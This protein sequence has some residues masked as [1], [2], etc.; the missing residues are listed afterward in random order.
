M[1]LLVKTPDA[2]AGVITLVTYSPKGMRVAVL[3]PDGTFGE[4]GLKDLVLEGH[5]KRLRKIRLRHKGK[6]EVH[7]N[8]A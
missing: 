4:Y 7:T 2:R 3:F 6:P 1:R 8:G 5:G